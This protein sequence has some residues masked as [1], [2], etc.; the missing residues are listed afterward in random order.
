MRYVNFITTASADKH[1]TFAPS[2]AKPTRGGQ[3]G[4]RAKDRQL[5]Q[6]D[7]ANAARAI[8]LLVQAIDAER[9]PLVAGLEFLHLLEPRRDRWRRAIVLRLRDDDGLRSFCERAIERLQGINGGHD[10]PQ[11]PDQRKAGVAAIKTIAALRE[12][13]AQIG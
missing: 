4:T 1:R 6:F 13:L 11:V 5:R 12:R 2:H 8:E 7:R 10:L 9:H 3:K